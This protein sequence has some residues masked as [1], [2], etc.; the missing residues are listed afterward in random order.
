[1]SSS[2]TSAST[3]GS[4]AIAALATIGWPSIIQFP[5]QKQNGTI[6]AALNGFCGDF[7]EFGSLD[8]REPLNVNQAENL[9]L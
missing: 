1:L 8:V 6:Q 9:P 4:S 5:L 7:Q 3:R 2:S